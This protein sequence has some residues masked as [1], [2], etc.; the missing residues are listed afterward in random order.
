MNEPS[1]ADIGKKAVNYSIFISVIMIIAGLWAIAQPYHAGLAINIFL[2]WM[3]VI[4]GF[5]HLVFAWYTR[6]SGGLALRFCWDFCISQLRSI[7][8]SIRNAGYAR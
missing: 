5:G 6:R 7:C 4:A 8:W 1:I 2:G 3:L